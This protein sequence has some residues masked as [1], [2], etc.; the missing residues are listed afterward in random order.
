MIGGPE[1]VPPRIVGTKYAVSGVLSREPGG[2][3]RL[4][5]EHTSIQRGVEIVMLDPSLA[6]DGPDAARLKKHARTLGAASHSGLQSLLDSG[7]DE[8]GRAYLVFDAP[9][10]KTVTDLLAADG[11]LDAA[12]AARITLQVLEAM[13]ALH[14]AR[15]VIRGLHP[16]QVV[17]LPRGEDHDVVKLRH[18]TCATFETDDAPPAVPYSPWSA[19]E[20]RRGES[21]LHPTS[22]VFSAGA[23]LRHLLTG[24]PTGSALRSTPAGSER[25]HAVEVAIPDTA[26]RALVRALSE[27]PDERFPNVDVFMQAVALLAPTELRPARDEMPLP[28][29]PLVADL[30]YLLLRKSTR[31]GTQAGDV[32]SGD[33]RAHLMPVLLV[34]EAVYR[35]LGTEAWDR[36]VETVPEVESLLPGAGNTPLNMSTGVPVALLASLL[37]AADD[38]GGVGDLGLIPILAHQVVERGLHRAFPALPTRLTPETLIEGFPYLWSQVQMQGTASVADREA[39][40]ARLLVRYQRQPQ[41]EVTGFVAALIRAA[42]RSVGA[43]EAE[44]HISAAAALGDQ[45]DVLRAHW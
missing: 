11:P 26:R 27:R 45:A 18:L 44:V 42:L 14:R 3:I 1:F 25:R 15:V 33:A 35:L 37:S 31:H 30:H 8:G 17:V 20:V 19:P 7:L 40:S 22:D 32:A 43:R 34:I 38:I 9:T 41:L 23:L 28:A 39:R 21:G 13:R 2:V 5:G 16:D 12:R 6:A 29:D 4:S 10:G 36:L 24:H